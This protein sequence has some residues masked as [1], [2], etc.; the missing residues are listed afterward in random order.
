MSP[1]MRKRLKIAAALKGITMRDY[2]LKAI[3][4]KL[5]QEEIEVVSAGSF[6]KLAIKRAKE[7]RE[8]V[9]GKYG[10]SDESV[11]IVRKARKQRSSRHQ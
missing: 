10:L 3:E 1:E 5:Q 7:V 6:N 11:E 8:Q 4:E 9:F 2:S